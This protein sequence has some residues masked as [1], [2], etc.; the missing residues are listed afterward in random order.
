[1]ITKEDIIKKINKETERLN[2]LSDDEINKLLIKQDYIPA[3][4]I[5]REVSIAAIITKSILTPEEL[6]ILR[7]QDSNKKKDMLS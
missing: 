1:M 4:D 2:K 6:K 7:S 3:E 5:N